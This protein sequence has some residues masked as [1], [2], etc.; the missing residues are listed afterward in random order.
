M[1]VDRLSLMGIITIPTGTEEG[2]GTKFESLK[3]KD[4]VITNTHHS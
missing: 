3:F 2:E 1:M 4:F